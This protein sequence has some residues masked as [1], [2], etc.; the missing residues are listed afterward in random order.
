[1]NKDLMM[2]NY[3]LK[4]NSI[5]EK[6][7]KLKNS[8]IS[9]EFE[10]LEGIDIFRVDNITKNNVSITFIFEKNNLNIDEFNNRLIF[11][12]DISNVD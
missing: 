1:M 6:L 12:L 10:Y 9:I 11:L 5:I 4:V 7:D 2:K 8:N 3:E